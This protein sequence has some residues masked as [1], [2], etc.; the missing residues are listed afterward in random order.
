VWAGLSLNGHVGVIVPLVIKTCSRQSLEE[1]ACRNLLPSGL[2]IG[3]FV[4]D[5]SHKD[6]IA[7]LPGFALV[8]K[9]AANFNSIYMAQNAM[10]TQG[11][12]LFAHYFLFIIRYAIAS[13]LSS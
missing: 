3:C 11:G 4:H 10:N 6:S 5:L 1:E 12:S 9:P 8:S 13:A 7:G 2:R